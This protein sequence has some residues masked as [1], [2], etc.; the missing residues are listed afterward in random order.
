MKPTR[1]HKF[2]LA[3]RKQKILFENKSKADNF[4][5]FN[6]ESIWEEN[7][8]APVRS[9]YCIFCC[10]WH[11]TSNPSVVQGERLDGRDELFIKRIEQ[12]KENDIELQAISK[13]V[14]EKILCFDTELNLCNFEEAQDILDILEFETNELRKLSF[15]IGKVNRILEKISRAKEKF[16]EKKKLFSLSKEEQKNWLDLEKPTI[17]DLKI[18]GTIKRI[19]SMKI[20]RSAL[21]NKKKLVFCKDSEMVMEII[22]ECRKYI[23]TAT[24]GNGAK[25]ARLR[26]N[27][28]LDEILKERNNQ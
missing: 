1:N 20:L 22:N 19:N 14:S 21:D 3:C 26:L 13:R 15:N 9:Y 2:C 5:K 16:A 17:E 24:I 6:A 7:K 12:Q 18:I 4:L 28:E 10:G 25:Q 27:E 8:K 11:V 23:Q